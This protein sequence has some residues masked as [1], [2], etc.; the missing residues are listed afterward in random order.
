MWFQCELH[1]GVS[2][3]LNF[4]IL[5]I[6][7]IWTLKFQYYLRE[8]FSMFYQYIVLLDEVHLLMVQHNIR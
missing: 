8:Y 5:S 4:T 2:E 1:V 7:V 6:T 3:K